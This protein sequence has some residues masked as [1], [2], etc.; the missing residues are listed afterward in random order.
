MFA[1][2]CTGMHPEDL[3]SGVYKACKS[4]PDLFQLV[5]LWPN[6][7]NKLRAS[8]LELVEAFLEK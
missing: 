2:E 5:E 6:L 7:S 3:T 8:I 1:P 4:Y